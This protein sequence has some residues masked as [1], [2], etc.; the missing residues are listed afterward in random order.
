MGPGAGHAAD[1][2]AYVLSRCA[3]QREGQDYDK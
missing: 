2:H 3:G 1:E